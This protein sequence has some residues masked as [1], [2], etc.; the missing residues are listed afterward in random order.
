MHPSYHFGTENAFEI[1]LKTRSENLTKLNSLR[2]LC[3]PSWWNNTKIVNYS[4]KCPETYEIL[5]RATALMSLEG[6]SRRA[7]Q[8]TAQ[9]KTLEPWRAMPSRRVRDIA[10]ERDGSL[11][12]LCRRPPVR[13]CLVRWAHCASGQGGTCSACALPRGSGPGSLESG[14]GGTVCT[15]QECRSEGS[16][17]GRWVRLGHGF[18]GCWGVLIT[19]KNR[20]PQQNV[21]A[22]L[23]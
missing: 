12:W 7:P 4:W 18:W 15:Q 6:R 23:E 13:C 5:R 19:L 22:K 20:E 10:R 1:I 8:S 11:L 3:T 14:E 9:S 2:A 21:S 17:L 16:E